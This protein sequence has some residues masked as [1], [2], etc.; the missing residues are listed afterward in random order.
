MKRRRYS[1][2]DEEHIDESWL[3]PYSDLLTLLLALFIV[4]FAS[5]SI[6]NDKLQQIMISMNS[7]LKGQG[8]SMILK[9]N[10]G[11]TKELEKS[12][13]QTNK[14]AETEKLQSLMGQIENYI[15]ERGLNKVITIQDEPKGIKLSLKDVILYESGS[16]E[17]K[18]DSLSILTDLLDLIKQ[19]ENPISI[20]GHTDN[21]P[22]TGGRFKSNWELSSARALTVL[23]FFEEKGIPSNKLQFSGFGE[24]KPIFPNDTLEH[25]QANRRVDITIL[26]TE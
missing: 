6:N 8:S 13:P 24:Q 10:S 11:I 26:K 22:I 17:L 7:A 16:A 2:H 1:N 18:G 9:E 25:R 14:Q 5:G 4:L 3:I 21:V 19:V 12:K 23:Y 20:E 15:N